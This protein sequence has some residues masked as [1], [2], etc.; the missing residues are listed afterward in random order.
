MSQAANTEDQRLAL[1]EVWADMKSDRNTVNRDPGGRE[2]VLAIRSL[3]RATRITERR[4]LH[5]AATAALA[6][7]MGRVPELRAEIHPDRLDEIERELKS[8]E[9]ATVAA[10]GEGLDDWADALDP[11]FDNDRFRF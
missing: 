6:C 4:E 9:A 11:N 10:V 1:L 7:L 3:R 2:I 8:L 5:D